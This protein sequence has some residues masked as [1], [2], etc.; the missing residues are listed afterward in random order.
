MLLARAIERWC[1]VHTSTIMMQLAGWFVQ[2]A[3]ASIIG[4]ATLCFP[5]LIW[6]NLSIR[7][8]RQQVHY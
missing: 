6:L 2:T 4:V 8:I 1:F 5:Y 3:V 7:N